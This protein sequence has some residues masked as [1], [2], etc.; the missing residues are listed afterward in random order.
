MH[1]GTQ[2]VDVRL[3]NPENAKMLRLLKRYAV[4][5][6]CAFPPPNE[7]RADQLTA[8]RELVESHGLSLDM[9]DMPLARTPLNP[10]MMGKSPERDRDIEQ[11]QE[12]I[13]NCAKAGIPS[14][15][16]YLSLLP[17]LSTQPTVGRG[18]SVS[19][20]WKLSDYS[21]ARDLTQAGRVPADL[22]WERIT[23]FLERVVPV[24]NEYRIRL[25]CHPHDVPTPPEFRGIDQVL[26]TP[27]GLKKF[28]SIQPSPYHGLNLCLGT[29]AEMLRD[30]ATEIFSIIRYF[31][32]RK[33][34]FNIHFRNIRGKRNA[35]Q[36]T[37]PDEG[38]MDMLKV[39]RTLKEVDYRYT[40]MPDH[41]PTHPDD[42]DTWQG[43][44]FAYGYIAA[45]LQAAA[46]SP[47]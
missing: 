12:L 11:T 36:E 4:N 24:A 33:K 22:M 26:G 32:E 10:I 37:F 3:A 28:V 16:Y 17:I 18:G 31:G 23:Y 14:V 6:V 15:K 9:V 39:I 29:T 38:D 43:F 20:V 30:P 35:F 34:I 46:L 19:R 44:A 47:L 41:I 21:Q 2:Q 1:L 42:P 27:E 7:W 45:L 25:A 13:R 5:H 8:L 40:L